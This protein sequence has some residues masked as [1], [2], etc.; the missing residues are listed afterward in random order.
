MS[1]KSA[2]S[3]AIALARE[4]DTVPVGSPAMD[5]YDAERAKLLQEF[6]RRLRELREQRFATQQA[7]ADAADLHRNQIGYLESG[8]REPSLSTLLILAQTLCVTLDD[9]AGG[10]VVPKERRAARRHSR[11]G[12]RSET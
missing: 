6:A 3:G 8:K 9:L 4:R 1:R 2:R 10:L 12:R 11:T 5:A 7:L